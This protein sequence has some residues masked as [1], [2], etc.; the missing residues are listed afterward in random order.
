LLRNFDKTLIL[1][2]NTSWFLAAILLGLHAGALAIVVTVPVPW[3]VRA[4]VAVLVGLSAYGTIRQIALRQG[5]GAVQAVELDHS[6]DWRL[7]V[8]GRDTLGPCRVLAC[9]VH[10]WIVVV[11][12]RCRGRRL[13]V[14]LVLTAD[15]V[16]REQLRALRVRLGGQHRAG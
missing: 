3:G 9:Y 1:N 8:G 10:P 14:G 2:L 13:P 12:L 4:A 5:Q 11:Q 7:S 6:G 15:A 16:D